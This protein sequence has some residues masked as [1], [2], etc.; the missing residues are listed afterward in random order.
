[1]AI[2]TSE[3]T[4][5]PMAEEE[6]ETSE[7]PS[8]QDQA[9]AN[10][11]K[12]REELDPMGS[13][14]GENG[15][16][17]KTP[18]QIEEEAK[19][20]RD[21][22]KTLRNTERQRLVQ[23]D[24]SS[25]IRALAESISSHIAT[26]GEGEDKWTKIAEAVAGHILGKEALK[27]ADAKALGQDI[28]LIEAKL[29]SQLDSS[30][31][32]KGV[33]DAKIEQAKIGVREGL[34]TALINGLVTGEHI[35][36]RINGGIVF[37]DSPG[38]EVDQ[39]EGA[40]PSRLAAYFTVS[41]EVG[42]VYL[43]KQFLSESADFKKGLVEHEFAHILNHDGPFEYETFEGFREAAFDLDKDKVEAVKKANPALG[44]ILDMLA[45]PDQDQ[46]IWNSYIA[47]RMQ[48]IA[49][50]PDGK[51]KFYARMKLAT[52]MAAEM[53]RYYMEAAGAGSDQEIEEAF[54]NARLGAIGDENQYLRWISRKLGV[55]EG[56]TTQLASALGISN[57]HD[58][59]ELI[60]AMVN[61]GKFPELFGLNHEWCQQLKTAFAKRGERI[62][63]A[64]HPNANYSAGVEGGFR[65]GEF[66]GGENSG[67]SGGAAQSPLTAI[68]EAAIGKKNQGEINLG[69]GSKG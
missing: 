39:N 28:A 56:N 19:R 59:H 42:K 44:K 4:Y 31:R 38:E 1:M 21:L 37:Q 53:T 64:N 58:H 46:E 25:E 20:Q 48:D 6:E 65:A 32:E 41:D 17:P 14:T 8:A 50:M 12:A 36:G 30:L 18:E 43:Y 13:G 54:L 57:V 69:L 63:K 2:E 40:D 7:E 22:D 55:P 60:Q 26:A 45:K 15:E 35:L 27:G 3:T 29:I 9:A 23:R 67:D 51:A 61:S 49:G 11:A 62:P 47:G 34:Y 66:G 52:E 5:D 33:D 16:K 10:Q 24:R 68:W